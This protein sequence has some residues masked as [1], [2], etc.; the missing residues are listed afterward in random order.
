MN[1][2]DKNTCAGDLLRAD[3]RNSF[4]VEENKLI[5]EVLTLIPNNTNLVNTLGDIFLHYRKE[6]R[7]SHNYQIELIAEIETLKTRP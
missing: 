2:I 3:P 4:E 5:N 6:L 1:V 7:H